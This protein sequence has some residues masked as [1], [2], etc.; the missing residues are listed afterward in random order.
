MSTESTVGI[1]ESLRLELEFNRGTLPASRA[2]RDVDELSGWP[3]LDPRPASL[4]NCQGL[5]QTVD[6]WLAIC[7]RASNLYVPNAEPEPA[8]LHGV[9]GLRDVGSQSAVIRLHYGSPFLFNVAL[10]DVLTPVGLGFLFYGA[11][12]LFGIDLEF[13]TYRE[14]KRSEYLEA[15]AHRKALEEAEPRL[16]EDEISV[17]GPAANRG[18]PFGRV[19]L[20]KSWRLRRGRVTDE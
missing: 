20:P 10:S 1:A 3:F 14:S 13:L 17:S 9:T 19:H 15:Q 2:P 18:D 8:M 5:V 7:E 11:K 4:E 6:Q 12:R 16:K